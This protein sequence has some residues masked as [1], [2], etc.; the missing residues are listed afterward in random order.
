MR[1][2]LLLALALPSAS[3]ALPGPNAARPQA[4]PRA[5]DC[6]ADLRLRSARRPGKAAKLTPLGEEP[7]AAIILTVYR[8]VGGCLEPAIVR[9]GLGR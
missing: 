3:A 1:L 2:L 5:P 6:R 4:S 7:P 8:E 9:T